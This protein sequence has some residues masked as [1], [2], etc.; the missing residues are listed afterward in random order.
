[1]YS[2]KKRLNKILAETLFNKL[3]TAKEQQTKEAKEFVKELK[4]GG[5]TAIEEPQSFP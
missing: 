3:R 4:A 5:G 1:M 2:L